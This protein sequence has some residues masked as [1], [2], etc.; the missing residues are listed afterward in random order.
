M[1]LKII[2]MGTP[3]FSIPTLEALV[4]RNHKVLMVYT[5]SP[6]R[7]K[8]GQ[9][10][11]ISP[12]QMFAKAKNIPFRNTENLD[13]NEY[14]IIKNLSADLGIVVAYGK[15]IPKNITST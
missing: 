10:I 13:S 14:E 7:S 2:F 9:K 11:N 12:I 4:N 3:E 6:K 8:R 5:Q 1:S 15:L